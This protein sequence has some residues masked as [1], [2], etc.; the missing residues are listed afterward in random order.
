MM[1]MTALSIVLLSLLAFALVAALGSWWL[2]LWGKGS[3]AT[4]FERGVYDRERPFVPPTLVKDG[5]AIYSVGEG[6]PILL[7][8]YPHAGTETPMAQGELAGL[9]A[10]LGRRVIT[11]D[12]PG[13]YASTREPRVSMDEMLACSHEALDAMGITDPVD[14]AGHSMGGLVAL[15]FALDRHG[16]VQRLLLLNSLS[17]FP[18]ALRWG[19]PGSVW[20]WTQAEYWQVVFWGLRLKNGRADLATHKRLMNLMDSVSFVDKNLAPVQVIQPGDEERLTPVRFQWSNAVWD[21]DYRERLREV[22]APALVTGGPRDPV[23]RLPCAQELAAG[24][25]KSKLAVFER[26]GHCPFIEEREH[27]V[28]ALRAFFAAT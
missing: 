1:M 28:G 15:A 27:F 13:A 18:A 19:M 17:G 12:P 4:N 26:S 23:T 10:S 6:E 21:I 9:L 16:R 8:P 20:S 22:R 24:I 25:A 7:L 3:Y 14:V 5:L 2:G 11:F